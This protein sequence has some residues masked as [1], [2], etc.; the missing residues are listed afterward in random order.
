LFIDVDGVVSPIVKD[1]SG[2]NVVPDGY[3]TYPGAPWQMPF[4]NEM[5]GWLEQLDSVFEARWLT[6][7][8]DM[9]P[10]VAARR[11]CPSGRFCRSW[12]DGTGERAWTARSRRWFGCSNKIRDLG[13][14]RTISITDADALPGSPVTGSLTW[15]S[16]PAQLLA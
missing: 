13:R 1:G 2:R 14:G 3:W 15:S 9:W 7:W 16:R 5:A 6:T 8:D 4:R 12:R 10:P 11:A